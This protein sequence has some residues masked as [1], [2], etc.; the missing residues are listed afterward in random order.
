MVLPSTAARLTLYSVKACRP[1][2]TVVVVVLS[3]SSLVQPSSSP[4]SPPRCRRGQAVAVQC[5]GSQPGPGTQVRAR[6]EEPGLPGPQVR[7]WGAAR[8]GADSSREYSQTP[9]SRAEQGSPFQP[10]LPAWPRYR[11]RYS[12]WKVP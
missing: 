3:T 2:S 7:A 10:L 11:Y 8:S 4:S 6:E 5:V 12:T 9:C 1:P